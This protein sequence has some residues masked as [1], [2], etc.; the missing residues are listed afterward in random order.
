L[1]SI[2]GRQISRGTVY[3]AISLTFFYRVWSVFS[4]FNDNYRESADRQ[5]ILRGLSAL[6]TV[7]LSTGITSL[8]SPVSQVVLVLAMFIG[9]LS[10][11]A[12]SLK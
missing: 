4:Y 9:R 6:S 10:P 2:Y 5:N 1:V 8:L 11:L 3:R 12:L 7:G